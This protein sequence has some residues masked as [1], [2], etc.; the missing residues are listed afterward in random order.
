M[1]SFKQYKSGMKFKR[2][3]ILEKF[4]D[5]IDKK[6][7]I[8]GSGAGI[9]LSAKCEE[10]GGAD[11]I[12]CYN[13][14]YFRMQGR[15]SLAGSLPLCDANSMLYQFARE[16]IPV[17][18][19]TPIMAGV[20]AH[21][22]FLDMPRFLKELEELGYSGIQNFPTLGWPGGPRSA[23][24]QGS[25]FG[26]DNEVK[27]IKLAHEMDFLTTPYVWD[28]EQTVAM[29]KAG[30]DIIVVHAAQTTG[31]T[32]GI[33]RS[34]I[35]NIDETCAFVQHCRDTAAAIREDIIV[36]AHG[37]PIAYP[38]DLE[39]LLQHTNGI[40]GFYGASSCER[41]PV[42]EAIPKRIREFKSVKFS[43]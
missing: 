27:L 22:P 8:I 31:G 42:E 3:D 4:R 28:D 7:P 21:D 38:A 24:M 19:H 14:G 36:I 23:I 26:Y 12:I 29:V 33:D 16:I 39:Y 9:G 34:L 13:T 35:R 1:Y 25:G 6:V 41:L 37:G 40:H 15:S 43:L 11:L 32:I 10:L 5:N 30:A 2:K 20:F 18:K 17:V